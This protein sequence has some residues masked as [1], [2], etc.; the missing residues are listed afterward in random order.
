MRKI[1]SIISGLLLAAGV[2]YLASISGSNDKTF[3]ELDELITIEH[4]Q[5]RSDYV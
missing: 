5:L 1:F 3:R 4:K 2:Y